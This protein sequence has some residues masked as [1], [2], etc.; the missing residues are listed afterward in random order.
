MTQN[1][2]QARGSLRRLK[3]KNKNKQYLSNYQPVSTLPFAQI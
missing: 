1:L 3:R 2:S